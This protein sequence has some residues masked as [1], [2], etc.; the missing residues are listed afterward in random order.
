MRTDRG[1][2]QWIDVGIHNEACIT[3]PDTCGA[4]GGAVSLWVKVI[5]CGFDDGIFTTME[6]TQMRGVAIT[7]YPPNIKYVRE[8]P[9]SHFNC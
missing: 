8:Y 6:N 2:N 7:C 1:I 9:R 5:D 4:A 3:Q